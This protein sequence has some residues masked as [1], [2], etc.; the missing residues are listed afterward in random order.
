MIARVLVALVACAISLGAQQR[1]STRVER[2]RI[3][4]LATRDGH[5]VLGL[6]AADFDV[7]DNGV[8][9]QVTLA[10]NT[11][12]PVNVLI[13]LDTSGS[14]S[15]ERLD[16]LR[17]ASRTVLRNL[18]PGESAGLMTFS[19]AIRQLQPMTMELERVDA[20]LTEV[21]PSGYTALID[22]VSA[23]VSA[24]EEASGRVLLLVFSDGTDT[25]S[26]HDADTVVAAARRS[27]TVL[28]GISVTPRGE[29]DP[30][31]RNAAHATGGKVFEVQA[32]NR[33]ESTFAQIL[34]EFRQRYLLSYTPT[35]VTKPGWHRLDVRVKKPG[36]SVRARPGYFAK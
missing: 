25:D 31:L 5:P 30:F 3:D 36:V 26:W 32:N 10:D 23:G 18:R 24:A 6:T 2:V 19:H 15:A 12:V 11:R 9:Q 1:F 22:A 34:D 14:L 28:Y 20:A 27:E 35:G 33:L 7:R 16:D 8:T 4:V 29:S 17:K 13:A 21:K